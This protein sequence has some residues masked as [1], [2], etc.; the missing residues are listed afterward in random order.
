MRIGFAIAEGADERSEFAAATLAHDPLQRIVKSCITA[1]MLIGEVHARPRCPRPSS[2]ADAVDDPG[3]AHGSEFGRY[4]LGTRRLEEALLG[5]E[6]PIRHECDV[7]HIAGSAPDIDRGPVGLRGC[8]PQ[9]ALHWASGRERGRAP[10][11]RP[12]AGIRADRGRTPLPLSGRALSLKRSWAGEV[13]NSLAAG[14]RSLPQGCR[15]LLAS[16]RRQPDEGAK[17]DKK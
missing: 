15:R 14:L 9:H 1:P 13:R 2:H 8:T 6:M 4:R 17:E 12:L 5:M 3:Q 11:S 16:S 7:T 10:R